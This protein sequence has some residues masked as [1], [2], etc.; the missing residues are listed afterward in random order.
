VPVVGRACPGGSREE[1]TTRNQRR[2]TS[3]K[4][5][6]RRIAGP[7]GQ[8]GA[9]EKT[10]KFDSKTGDLDSSPL[11]VARYAPLQG[12]AHAALC[13]PDVLLSDMSTD[14]I[15]RGVGWLAGFALA[16]SFLET[17]ISP[18]FHTGECPADATTC[19]LPVNA[20]IHLQY[21]GAGALT[22]VVVTIDVYPKNITTATEKL[23]G[24]VNILLCNTTFLAHAV[25]F[26]I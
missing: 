19:V 22:D 24:L 16:Q 10:G 23:T 9:V 26:C 7:A 15:S 20:N 8:G 1:R 6:W 2:R 4:R 25:V 11:H 13:P 21:K 17:E 12:Y 5:C 3:G 18:L 14:V